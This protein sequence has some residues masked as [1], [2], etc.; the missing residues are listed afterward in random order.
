MQATR[1][2]HSRA[3][4]LFSSL[5]AMVALLLVSAD[6]HARRISIDFGGN[7]ESGD[8]W[9][10]DS[11]GCDVF[12]ST[13]VQSCG[14]SFAGLNGTTAAVKLG[15]SVKIGN[16]LYDELYINK[17]GFV[18]FGVPFSIPDGGFVAATDIAGVQ[19]VVS[20]VQNR[21]FIAPFYSNLTLPDRDL[22][23]FNLQLFDANLGG[24][25]GYFV[26]GASY[27]RATSDPTPSDP[28]ERV[29]RLP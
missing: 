27:Y 23:E 25:F 4:T 16:Q 22:R 29:Q 5:L 12:G 1:P 19:G 14:V 15:F 6:S 3:T 2:R 17:Y 26:G 13:A 20:P 28:A 7:T 8:A 9:A 24:P 18:T 10:F 21:P 11:T